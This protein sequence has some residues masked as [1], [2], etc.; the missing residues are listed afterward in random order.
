MF[1]V[2]PTFL[3]KALDKVLSKQLKNCDHVNKKELVDLHK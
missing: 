2:Y 3:R 1:D